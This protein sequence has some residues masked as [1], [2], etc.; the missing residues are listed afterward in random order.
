[1][2]K[3]KWTKVGGIVED[4]LVMVTSKTVF[5]KFAFLERYI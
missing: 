5:E 2:T 3:K 4:V 1:M